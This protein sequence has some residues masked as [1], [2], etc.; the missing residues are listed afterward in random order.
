MKK[1]Q[2]AKELND[3]KKI[4]NL[5]GKDGLLH[6]NGAA[7]VFFSPEL[8]A[9]VFCEIGGI[10]PHRMNLESISNPSIELFNNY[11]G[12]FPWPSPE[13]GPFG[14]C[15]EEDRWYV[16]P[17]VN[18]V[19]FMMENKSKSAAK[20]IKKTILVNR[21]GV[22][23]KLIMQR[24]FTAAPLNAAIAALKPLSWA[25]YTVF[26]SIIVTNQ[27]K[28]SDAL[29]SCWTLEQMNA[30]DNTIA[31][32][33][34]RNPRLSIDFDYYNNP[35]D[36]ITYFANGFFFQ[37]NSQCN[38]QICVKKEA[39][40]ELIGFYDLKRKL[41]GVREIIG[42]PRGLYFNISANDKPQNPF[43]A[44]HNYSIYNSDKDMSFFEIETLGGADIE[45]GFLKGS[46]LASK[47]SFAI[48]DDDKPLL[49][50]INSIKYSNRIQS[51]SR[52]KHSA[53]N[54]KIR[55]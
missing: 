13:G 15:Y 21:K 54:A 14:F 44:G 2:T 26:D 38:C 6:N 20:A 12:N 29:I 53:Q 31:F 48:F 30:N 1:N 3:F 10:I 51:Y 25:A 46:H 52:K 37:A 16:Q 18:N 40:A 43:S 22:E 5:K 36:R 39:D 8:G 33:K 27:V 17:G 9:R 49:N 19:P 23:V 50:F 42:G 11:G 34:V 32:V 41:L 4:L 7:R 45:E 24:E 55:Q 28:A 35:Q 47:T